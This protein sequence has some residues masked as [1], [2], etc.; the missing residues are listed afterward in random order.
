LEFP[1]FNA[2]VLNFNAGVPD[3]LVEV[4]DCFEAVNSRIVGVDGL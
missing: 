3:C 4:P 2:G 1:D